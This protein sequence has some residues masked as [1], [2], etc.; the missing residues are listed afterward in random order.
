[1]YNVFMQYLIYIV[2][3]TYTCFVRVYVH[4]HTCTCT[5]SNSNTLDSS[6]SQTTLSCNVKECKCRMWGGEGGGECEGETMG[7]VRGEW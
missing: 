2:D 1:M 6:G 4:A 3:T 7:G 5:F